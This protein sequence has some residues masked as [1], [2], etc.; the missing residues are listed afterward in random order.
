MNNQLNHSEIKREV[1]KK[2]IILIAEDLQRPSNYGGLIRTAESLGV[3][4]IIFISKEITELSTK[5]K[6]VSRSAEKNIKI[7]F[8]D[9]ILAILNN[10][11]F[12]SYQKIA[13]EFTNK[14]IPVHQF[15]T[16]S[17]K[18]ILV[19]GNENKGISEDV[20]NTIQDTIKI[21]VYGTTSSLNVVV[22]TGI[23]LNHLI[24]S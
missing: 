11:K 5:M 19:C 22:A 18:L 21:P 2:E 8:S 14:S 4:Q 24:N 23:A 15:K 17:D 6:R 16:D 13:L 3:K 12:N 1:P 7:T 10:Q 20:L 9:D